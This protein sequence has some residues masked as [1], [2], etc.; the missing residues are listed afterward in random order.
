DA[1]RGGEGRASRR[2]RELPHLQ[3]ELDRFRPDLRS[4]HRR[5]RQGFRGAGADRLRPRAD[6][7]GTRDRVRLPDPDDLHGRARRHA[8]HA[9]S[10]GPGGRGDGRAPL[11]RPARSLADT[12]HPET[13]LRPARPWAQHRSARA[14]PRPPIPNDS[15]VSGGI[16]PGQ[17]VGSSQLGTEGSAAWIAT[18]AAVDPRSRLA[19]TGADAPPRPSPRISSA[20]ASDPSSSETPPASESPRSRKN[21]SK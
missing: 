14:T 7:P 11:T 9:L 17:A 20:V 19:E 8:G 18:R 16:P 3:P 6:L 21:F 1:R 4:R 13:A 10:S 12:D 15:R 2:A 5:G